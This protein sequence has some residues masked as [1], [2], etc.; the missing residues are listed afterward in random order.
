MFWTNGSIYASLGL[1]GLMYYVGGTLG[2]QCI[3]FTKSTAANLWH[4][5]YAKQCVEETV[6]IP[7]ICDTMM[8]MWRNRDW[9]SSG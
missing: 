4:C 7:V 8:F 1:N 5:G 9:I 6:E 3:P 2:H